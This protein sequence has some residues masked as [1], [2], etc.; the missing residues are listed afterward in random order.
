[1]KKLLLF[2]FLYSLTFTVCSQTVVTLTLPD[3]CN[4]N[5]TGVENLINNNGFEITLS[6]NPND[7][8]FYLLV[9]APQ[10]INK[11]KICILDIKGKIVFDEYIYSNSNKYVKYFNIENLNKGIYVIFLQNTSYSITKKLIIK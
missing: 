11:A 6:P 1:M 8:K 7:G 9:S 4:K 2:F 5:V 3:N 10:R